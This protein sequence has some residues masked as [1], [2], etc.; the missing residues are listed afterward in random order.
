MQRRLSAYGQELESSL[1]GRH[2][3]DEHGIGTIKLREQPLQVTNLRQVVDGDVGIGWIA[4]EKI[5]MIPFGRVKRMTRLD[6][7][8]DGT[9]EGVRLIELINIGLGDLCLLRVN[10]KDG[11]AI[12]RADIGSLTVE[13]RTIVSDREI[14][15]ENLGIADRSRVKGD[16]N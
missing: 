10:G 6:L 16:P 1:S 15:L 12:L 7:G 14:D 13:F 2:I 11:R 9:V 4:G 8:N 3:G 5:L